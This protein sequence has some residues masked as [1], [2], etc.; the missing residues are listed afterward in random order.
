MDGRPQVVLSRICEQLLRVLG[1]QERPLTLRHLGSVVEREKG[2]ASAMGSGVFK[3]RRTLRP[4]MDWSVSRLLDSESRHLLSSI[5]LL[6][7]QLGSFPE[8]NLGF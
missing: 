6:D 5:G 3:E 8:P 4:A 7:T 1:H 2:P